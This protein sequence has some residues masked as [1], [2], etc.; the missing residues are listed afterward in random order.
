MNMLD[1][2]MD[3]MVTA[4][5]PHWGEAWSRVQVQGSLNLPNT[6]V[7]ILD[8]QGNPWAEETEPAGFLLS[9]SVTGEEEMLLVAVK[10]QFRGAGI[11]AALIELFIDNA[12][13]RGAELLFLEMRENNPA[14]AL[15]SRYAFEP[16]G[17]RR[18]YY[19]LS[20]KSKLDAITFRR[21]L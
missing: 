17:R 3:I 16:I 13:H 2:I 6:H 10:P 7:I 20:D 9:R 5:D 8:A 18:D 14:I 15:Y 1:A 12:Q 11:G 4:F 19:T 21:K